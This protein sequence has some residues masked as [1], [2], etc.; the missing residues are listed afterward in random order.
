VGNLSFGSSHAQVLPL[1]GW[2][3]HRRQFPSSV[4]GLLYSDLSILKNLFSESGYC[5]GGAFET[6][7]TGTEAV[8]VGIGFGGMREVLALRKGGGGE[9][10]S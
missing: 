5:F 3:L 9:G 2:F 4:L 10:G 8:V 6:G 7:V 1:G